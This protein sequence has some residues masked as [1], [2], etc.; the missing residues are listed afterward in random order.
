MLER[1]RD[2]APGLWPK[3]LTQSY[4]NG[5]G[6][7]SK[8]W[9]WITGRGLAG[10]TSN[11]VKDDSEPTETFFFFSVVSR[12]ELIEE[13]IRISIY[14]FFVNVYHYVYIHVDV[15]ICIYVCT[16]HTHIYIYIYTYIRRRVFLHVYIHTGTSYTKSGT[17]TYRSF[18]SPN[19]YVTLYRK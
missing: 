15:L 11:L 10:S 14:S 6:F 16:A 2:V 8:M 4:A 5:V 19:V 17:H 12:C 7:W 3:W 9:Y 13:N 1:Q 18:Q